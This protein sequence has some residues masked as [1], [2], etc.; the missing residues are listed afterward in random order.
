MVSLV[1]SKDSVLTNFMSINI[2]LYSSGGDH[3]KF[4]LSERFCN[5][6]SEFY[7]EFTNRQ[8]HIESFDDLNSKYGP[9]LYLVD[10][11]Q[12]VQYLKLESNGETSNGN[13]VYISSVFVDDGMLKIRFLMNEFFLTGIE[14][15]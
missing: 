5:D 4:D 7:K 10:G 11:K 8:I 15:L 2:P 13:R 3:S 14:K 12:L 9:C 1:Y 6:C